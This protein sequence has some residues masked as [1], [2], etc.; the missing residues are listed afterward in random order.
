MSYFYNKNYQ[1]YK[2]VTSCVVKF[3]NFFSKSIKC[4][5]KPMLGKMMGLFSKTN[6]AASCS[7]ILCCCMMYAMVTVADLLTP[8]IQC[9][10]IGFCFSLAVLMNLMHST[11]SLE[12]SYVQSSSID[13]P[14][15]SL[16][17]PYTSLS[18]SLSLYAVFRIYT[19]PSSSI[20]ATSV[21]CLMLPR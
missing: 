13:S 3:Y 18:T 19:I 21:A 10:S 17:G 15:N 4:L 1:R 7:D 5:M 11:K 6:A 20:I 14:R 12:I 2:Y 9:I 8:A 16:A